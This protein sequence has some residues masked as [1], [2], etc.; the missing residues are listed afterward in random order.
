M[1]LAPVEL[2]GSVLLLQIAGENP[3]SDVSPAAAAQGKDA[4]YN[5]FPAQRSK[6]RSS[7]F[8]RGEFHFYL[9]P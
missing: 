9:N 7:E 4:G 2:G 6:Q 3:A 1:E 5:K 8:D